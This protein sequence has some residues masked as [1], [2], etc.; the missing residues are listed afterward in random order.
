MKYTPIIIIVFL[1]ISTIA[2]SGAKNETPHYNVVAEY[3]RSLGAIHNIQQ[4]EALELQES[5]NTYNPN[6][7]NILCSIYDSKRLI[8]ELNNSINDL[9]EIYLN[10]PFDT[11][12]TNTITFYNQKLEIHNELM[13]IEKTFITE[14]RKYDSYHSDMVA[15]VQELNDSLKP[16]SVNE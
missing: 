16:E 2:W 13:S 11:L 7:C 8:N 1:S 15:L 3:I 6:V 10:K 14:T 9:K 12:I 5:T 4:T